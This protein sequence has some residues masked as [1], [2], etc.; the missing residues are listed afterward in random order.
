MCLLSIGDSLALSLKKSVYR[1]LRRWC[2]IVKKWMK[3]A[4]RIS[5]F[6]KILNSEV[7][8]RKNECRNRDTIN[9]RWAGFYRNKAYGKK[10]LCTNSAFTASREGIP[11]STPWPFVL[12]MKTF[13]LQNGILNFIFS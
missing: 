12:L 7:L 13:K 11:F 4:L 5:R 3:Q 10:D 8:R 2:V 1:L 9:F 6:I